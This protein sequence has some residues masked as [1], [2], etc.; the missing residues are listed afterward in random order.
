MP[1][2]GLSLKVIS[3]T[4]KVTQGEKLYQKQSLRY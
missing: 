3:G 1:S 4:E 2:Y